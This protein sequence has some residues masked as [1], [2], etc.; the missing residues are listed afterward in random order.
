VESRLHLLTAVHE[1]IPH[2]VYGRTSPL[3]SQAQYWETF[4]SL[5]L[6]WSPPSQPQAAPLIPWPKLPLPLAQPSTLEL[7]LPCKYIPICPLLLII[8]HPQTFATASPPPRA[9]LQSPACPPS[10]AG[11]CNSVDGRSASPRLSPVISPLRVP[12]PPPLFPCSF[13]PFFPLFSPIILCVCKCFSVFVDALNFYYS[14]VHVR[15]Q[16][17]R[18]STHNQTFPSKST[19]STPLSM[20]ENA[21]ML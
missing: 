5:S 21:D 14:H 4:I 8:I 6:L 2:R 13:R 11:D 17:C 19:E 20:V 1:A 12:P 16:A 18:S 3:Q 9:F 10:Q 15:A 7:L